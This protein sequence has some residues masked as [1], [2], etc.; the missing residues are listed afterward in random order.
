MIIHSKKEEKVAFNPPNGS[1]LSMQTS[2]PRCS[3][4]PTGLRDNWYMI[5][6]FVHMTTRWASKRGPRARNRSGSESPLLQRDELRCITGR[7]FQRKLRLSQ[8]RRSRM[9]P[10]KAHATVSKMSLT[11]AIVPAW[12]LPNGG[13]GEGRA[14]SCGITYRGRV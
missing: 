4:Y 5:E 8:R 11:E 7:T 13:R 10:R 9:Q 3:R 14:T 12:L 2:K 6:Q 1:S